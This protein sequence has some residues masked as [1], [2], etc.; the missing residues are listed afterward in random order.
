MLCSVHLGLM[1]GVLTEAGGPLAAEAVRTSALPA[2]CTVQLRL[3][4][5][6]AA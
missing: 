6:T 4:E 5:M 1:Q 2:D 3:T